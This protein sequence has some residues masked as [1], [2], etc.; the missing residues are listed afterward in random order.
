MADSTNGMTIDASGDVTTCCY[1]SEML[2]KFGNVYDD[3]LSAVWGRFTALISSCL[4]DLPGCRTCIG[5]KTNY[6]PSAVCMDR[7]SIEKE[8]LSRDHGRFPKRLIIEPAALCN[9]ACEGCPANWNAKVLADLDRLY[10]GIKEGLPYIE[11]LGFGLYGEPL[12]HKG[13][14][15]FFVQCRSVAPQLKMQLLTNGTAL[16]KKTAKKIVDSEVDI[17]TVAIHAGPLTENMLKY[18]QRGADYELVLKNIETLVTTRDASPGARTQVQVRTVLFNW[19]DTDELMNRLRRDVAAAGIKFGK[20]YLYWV[21]DVA[22]PTAPRSSK[23]F[24]P[25]SA[26]LEALKEAG[27]FGAF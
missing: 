1:D 18:S 27:E 2:N 4:Y 17:V 11:F 7:L 8:W 19:N 12:L 10:D 20:D 24:V 13:L 3:G 6:S 26:D 16:T 5:L 21:L 23:R 14:G 22:G 9:Y 15:D 25:G